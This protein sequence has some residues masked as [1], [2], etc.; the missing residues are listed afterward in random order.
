MVLDRHS[1]EFFINGGEQTISITIPTPQDADGISF[2]S[3]GKVLMDVEKFDLDP[4]TAD[5]GR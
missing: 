2:Y 5:K 3:E 1:A 4:T